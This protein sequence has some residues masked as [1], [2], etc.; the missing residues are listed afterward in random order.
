MLA[1]H[2]GQKAKSLQSSTKRTDTT[3]GFINTNT[4]FFVALVIKESLYAGPSSFLG[5]V[6]SMACH[7][8]GIQP[9]LALIGASSASLDSPEALSD[10][11]SCPLRSFL[12]W[13]C[14]NSWMSSRHA[15]GFKCMHESNALTK[16][17]LEF[18]L[19]LDRFC[20]LYG[21]A[22]CHTEIR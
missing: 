17:L 11:L 21:V 16:L 2:K 4:L 15:I 22:G 20:L 7:V 6:L 18:P 3:K 14:S 9:T 12:R 1:Q 10:T 8:L 13:A 5:E 19:V